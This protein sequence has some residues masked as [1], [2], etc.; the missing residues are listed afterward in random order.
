MNYPFLGY[1]TPGLQLGQDS[2]MNAATPSYQAPVTSQ[3]F[4]NAVQPWQ[5]DLSNYATNSTYQAL[6]LDANGLYQPTGMD[7]TGWLSKA[8]NWMSKNTELV[9]AGAGLVTG[10]LGAWNGMQQNKLMR[11]N[12]NQQ[13]GQFREQMDLSKQNIN[14]NIEDRQRARVA[15][16]AQAYESV[17]SYM[18]KYGVK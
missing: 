15:S 10:G 7:N 2:W 6:G 16:N 18:K 13:A 1:N 8:N 9:K 11:E 3:P 5:T 14:R 17:D 4:A 12:M